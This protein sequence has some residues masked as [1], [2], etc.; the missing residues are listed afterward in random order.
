MYV[1]AVLLLGSF[2]I[3]CTGR[4]TNSGQSRFAL[5]AAIAATAV[6]FISGSAM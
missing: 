1:M 3:G 5:C 4:L 6:Y 2:L